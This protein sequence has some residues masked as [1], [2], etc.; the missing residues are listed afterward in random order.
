MKYTASVTMTGTVEVEAD[1]LE[2]A[3]DRIE[4]GFS[5]ADFHCEDVEVDEVYKA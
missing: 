2:E 4:D 3:K 1:T 5:M